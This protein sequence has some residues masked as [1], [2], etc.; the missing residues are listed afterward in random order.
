MS[1]GTL[2]KKL[3]QKHCPVSYSKK[4]RKRALSPWSLT[5]SS[6]ESELFRLDAHWDGLCGLVFITSSENYEKE[7]SPLPFWRSHWFDF[8]W[9]SQ[10]EVIAV[11]RWMCHEYWKLNQPPS[12]CSVCLMRVHAPA[13]ATLIL[14]F[15]LNTGCQDGPLCKKWKCSRE[16]L[17]FIYKDM[18]I[19][20]N[21]FC[22]EDTHA[23]VTAP[24]RASHYTKALT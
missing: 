7:W 23:C 2:T 1:I 17:T 12:L 9:A 16:L 5:E 8:F 19:Y 6:A 21:F 24:D 15:K 22:A 11:Y 20:I 18:T 13:P 10:F 14:Y 4:R 3:L